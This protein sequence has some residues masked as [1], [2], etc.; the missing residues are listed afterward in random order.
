[1]RHYAEKAAHSSG[2]FFDM[3]TGMPQ[4]C[5][6]ATDITLSATLFYYRVC[7]LKGLWEG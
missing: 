4:K 3:E 5:Y 7:E 6:S 2:I 1:M